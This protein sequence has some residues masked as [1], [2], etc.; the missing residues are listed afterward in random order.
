MGSEDGWSLEWDQDQERINEESGETPEQRKFR[1]IREE[2]DRII[3]GLE[4][5]TDQP[6]D[7]KDG[8]CPMLDLKVWT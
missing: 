1:L 3:P 5:T 8:R 6:S 4:F 7:N 2:A